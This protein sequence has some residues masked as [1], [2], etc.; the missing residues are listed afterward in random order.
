[1]NMNVNNT[2]AMDEEVISTKVQ[3]HSLKKIT[4][5]R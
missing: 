5:F 3:R 4:S 2:I 1:M